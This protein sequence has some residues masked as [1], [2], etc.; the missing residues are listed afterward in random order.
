ML[1]WQN[2]LAF[3]MIQYDTQKP[4]LIKIIVLLVVESDVGDLKD[5]NEQNILDR[6]FLEKKE[7]R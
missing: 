7:K 2:V 3:N 4:R 6:E 1:N 5:K